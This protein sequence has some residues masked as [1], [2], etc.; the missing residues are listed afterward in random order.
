MLLRLTPFPRLRHL[1]D[2]TRS[3]GT[4][5][6]SSCCGAGPTASRRTPRRRSASTATTRCRCSSATASSAGANVGDRVELGWVSRVRPPKRA[7]DDELQRLRH[8]LY[9]ILSMAMNMSTDCRS[10]VR[11]FSTSCNSATAA[12]HRSS[13]IHRRSFA[14]CLRRGVPRLK[15]LALRWFARTMRR[16]VEASGFTTNDNFAGISR[17]QTGGH[18]GI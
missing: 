6:A 14:S 7:V 1:H 13:A 11:R 2:R 8:F 18:C 4:A 10:F 15:P 5:A 16:D 9:N 12:S 17:F 3:C